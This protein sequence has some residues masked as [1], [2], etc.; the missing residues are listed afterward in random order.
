M[1]ELMILLRVTLKTNHATASSHKAPLNKC[2]CLIRF[3][4]VDFIHLCVPGIILYFIAS[5]TLLYS[6]SPPYAALI[7]NL[8]YWAH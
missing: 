6:E 7:L 8:T 2:F 3:T 1:V 5:S 4:N